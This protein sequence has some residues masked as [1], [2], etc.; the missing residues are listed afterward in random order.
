MSTGAPHAPAD[1]GCTHVMR[2]VGEVLADLVGTEMT[3]AQRT[4]V[5]ELAALT[6]S[7]PKT[8]RSAANA[9]YYQNRKVRAQTSPATDSVSENPTETGLKNTEK[10]LKSSP[11]RVEDNLLF[12]SQDGKKEKVHKRGSRLRTEWTPN[13]LDAA[14]T[15]KHGLTAEEIDHAL[16]EFRDY[17]SAVAG[18]HGSKLDWNATWRNR[19]RTLGVQKRDR[20]ARLAARSHQSIGNRRGDVSFA[21]I[22]AQR[23]GLTPH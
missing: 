7:A 20:V 14:F 9:R 2:S 3:D 1:V 11:T 23:R 12:E 19:L 16:G 5:L 13:E 6:G 10:V 4:L 22:V 21:D 15:L 8:D 18:S 17:W